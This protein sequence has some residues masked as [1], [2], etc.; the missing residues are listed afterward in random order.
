M[1][2]EIKSARLEDLEHLTILIREFYTIEEISFSSAVVEV[3]GE[4]IKNEIFGKCL[5]VTLDGQLIGY[6]VLTYG[7]SLEY[8]GRYSFIDEIYISEQHRSLGLGARLLE[9][10][11][12]H[13]RKLGIGTVHLE[14]DHDNINAH[15][16][17]VRQGFG[18]H[19]RFLMS[20]ALANTSHK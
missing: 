13:A 4:L 14:V 2:I 16:F 20:K 9:A 8:G 17:Y 5:I 6:S 15:R 3:L 18:D 7:F 10:V 1:T 12:D 11:E 19:G